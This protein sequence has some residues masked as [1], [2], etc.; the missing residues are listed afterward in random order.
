[1]QKRKPEYLEG[2]EATENF[3][4]GMQALFQVP[5]FPLKKK[6]QQDKPYCFREETESLRQGLEGDL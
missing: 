2:Q 5:K 6:K 1:M 3:E 4:H